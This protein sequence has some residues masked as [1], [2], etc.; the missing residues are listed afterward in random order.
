M[1]I[2]SLL[3]GAA[4]TAALFAIASSILTAVTRRKRNS[5]RGNP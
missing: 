5:S 2:D 3:V 1:S 4:V